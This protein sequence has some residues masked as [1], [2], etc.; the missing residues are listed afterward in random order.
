MSLKALALALPLAVMSCGAA[1]QELEKNG[2]PCVPELCIG[3]SLQ[4]LAK[5]SWQPAQQRYKLNN[6]PAQKRA[7][8][9]FVDRKPK[10]G[11]RLTEAQRSLATE[12]QRY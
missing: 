6:K 12:L 5:I 3:D 2:L 4:D 11:S 10:P 1:A 9:R 7:F 8:E